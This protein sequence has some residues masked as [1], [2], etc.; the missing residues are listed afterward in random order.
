MKKADVKIGGVYSANVS[1]NKTKV[2]ID[3]ESRGGGWTATNLAT[4]KKVTIR[5]AQRLHGEVLAKSKT[6]KTTTQDN[7]TVV[8]VPPATVETVGGAIQEQPALVLRKPT[9][10]KKAKSDSTKATDET[11]AKPEKRLSCV[12]AAI[13]VLAESAEPLSTKQIVE[14]MS[15]KGYWSSPGGKTPEAT[16][17]SA[18]LRDISKGDASRFVKAD[19][20]RFVVRAAQ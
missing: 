7:L 16:L 4:N 3:A 11:A 5:T 19:R 12:T 14:A 20:G 1:G 15:T 10:A 18:I 13:K 9:K 17:Y 6:T 2:R 8:E